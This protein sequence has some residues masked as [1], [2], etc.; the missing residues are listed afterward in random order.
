MF[1]NETS[2]TMAN[3]LKDRLGLDTAPKM[4]NPDA[5]LSV[6]GSGVLATVRVTSKRFAFSVK[7]E[8]L[9]LVPLATKRQDKVVAAINSILSGSQR[10]SLLPKDALTIV[11][12]T[13]G[14]LKTM[15]TPEQTER[16]VRFLFPTRYENGSLPDNPTASSWH[17]VPLN[18][19]TFIPLSAWDEWNKQFEAAKSAH[20]ACADQIIENYDRL[21]ASSVR[22][23][24]QIGLDVYRRLEITAPERLTYQS[25]EWVDGEYVTISKTTTPLEWCRRWKRII[26]ASW[27]TRAQIKI[28]FSVE[29][30]FFFAPMPSEIVKDRIVAE[31][32]YNA[33]INKRDAY[34]SLIDRVRE[35]QQSQVHELTVAYVKTI[36]ERSE[37]VFLGF[38]NF[39]KN[40]NRNVSARQLNSVLR[41]A[42]MIKTMSEGVSSLE[43]IQ[44]QAMSIETYIKENKSSL[45]QNGS[46]KNGTKQTAADTD[47]PEIIAHALQVV[48]QEAESL[49][50]L[51]ARRTAFS[52]EDPALIF[53]PSQDQE[54]DSRR[55]IAPESDEAPE[56]TPFIATAPHIHTEIDDEMASIRR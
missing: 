26:L 1:I 56:M 28:A 6:F 34:N 43:K 16:R 49:I 10:A 8:D 21:K 15:A 46:R 54:V 11:D 22:H 53:L 24:M 38:L 25:S 13:N 29:A 4:I 19:M 20:L 36:V 27:P 32:Q 45:I 12:P 51:E 18:G 41:V 50:G 35:T 7:I 30:K 33:Y 39:A 47:L 14:S 37:M 48:R 3:S 44:E 55:Y 42:D 17:A 2:Q 40:G 9:G 23:W 5:M 52:D 31:E